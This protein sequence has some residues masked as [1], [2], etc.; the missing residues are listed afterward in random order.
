MNEAEP[1]K[2]MKPNCVLT[3]KKVLVMTKKMQRK[4]MLRKM[5]IHIK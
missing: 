4:F 2:D 3:I 5:T 1:T